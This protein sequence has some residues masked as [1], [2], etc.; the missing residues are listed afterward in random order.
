[1]G[2]GS[3]GAA[4]GGGAIYGLG[5]LGA[6]FY[7]WQQAEA[8]WEY[9]WAIFPK[10]IFWAGVH[11][12]RGA[13]SARRVMADRSSSET[14]AC[15]AVSTGLDGGRLS[16]SPKGGSYCEATRVDRWRT[17]ACSGSRVEERP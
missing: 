5:I 10:A 9:I 7:Y 1:M 4:E 13:Q 2:N 17:L 8:F 16:V 14:Q 15:V 3:T 12:L 6:L 11:G